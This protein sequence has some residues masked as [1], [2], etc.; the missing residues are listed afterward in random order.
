MKFANIFFQEGKAQVKKITNLYLPKRDEE[1]GAS[2]GFSVRSLWLLA[3]ASKTVPFPCPI[4]DVSVFLTL[5]KQKCNIN[6][7][8]RVTYLKQKRG[9][10]PKLINRY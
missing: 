10:L 1:V 2:T 6:W 4:F 7:N 3:S 9:F 5:T 8:V